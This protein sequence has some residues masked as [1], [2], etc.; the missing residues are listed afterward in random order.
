VEFSAQIRL[1]RLVNRQVSEMRLPRI[2]VPVTSQVLPCLGFLIAV[3]P[4]DTA[5]S[6]MRLEAARACAAGLERGRV[7][8]ESHPGPPD[9]AIAVLL[10]S[11]ESLPRARSLAAIFRTRREAAR[12]RSVVTVPAAR[13]LHPPSCPHQLADRPGQQPGV[14]RVGHVRRIT[15]V[16][17]RTRAVRSSFARPPWPAAPRLARPPHLPRTG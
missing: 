7:A 14:R 10:S 6:F 16:S 13:G 3:L 2:A 9:Q 1:L 17:A 5:K 4:R 11:R 8:C 12:R 15:V